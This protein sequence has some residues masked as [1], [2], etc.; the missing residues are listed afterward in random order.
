MPAASSRIVA[1]DIARHDF[2]LRHPSVVA[3]G[4][5]ETAP[6]II[7][8]ISLENGLVGWGCAAPDEH[9]TGESPEMVEQTLRAVFSEPLLS[10]DARRIESIWED[11]RQLAPRQPSALAAVDIALY[12]LFGQ[13]LGLP[14]ADLFGASR[15]QIPTTITLSI[16]PLE[17]NLARTTEF[18]AAG[19]RALKIKCGVDLHEDIARIRA[20]RQLAGPEV[21]LTL[22]ANQG[23]DVETTLR[24]LDAVAD[25]RCAFIEQPVPADDLAALARL[26]ARSPLPVMAD[27]SILDAGDVAKTP[28]PLVN[29]KLMKTGG[30]TGAL[31][32]NAVAAA[33][34]IGVM[35]GCMDESCVSMAAAAHLALGLRSVVYADLDGHT[36]L[37][38]DVVSGGISIEDGQVTVGAAP[39][40]GLDHY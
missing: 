17:K 13:T 7:V 24:L 40:L 12:D 9:V 8:R 35:F 19:F 33:R 6:N 37:L 1:I 4:G 18:L 34:G 22:D 23:Y 27:E 14:L 29:L 16:E 38:E 36:D 5:V 32:C 15:R 31:K 20:I 21:T 39:G 28:A 3:Y 25:C 30:I 2:P 11:L 26:C 10:R